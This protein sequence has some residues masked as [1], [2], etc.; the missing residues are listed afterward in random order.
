MKNPYNIG[1]VF[2]PDFYGRQALV[3]QL[4]DE[5][6]QCI[7]LVGNRR[8]GKTSMLR[9]LEE[10]AS[11]V[12]LFLDLMSTGASLLGME[13]GAGLVRQVRRKS[14]RHPFLKEL[15]FPE[16]CSICDAVAILSQA[17]E[18]GSYSVLLLI[19]EAEKLLEIKADELARLRSALQ[20]KGPL[21]TILAATQWLAELNEQ[22]GSPL[23]RPFLYGFATHYLPP[24][25]D[26]DAT[27]LILQVQNLE[28]QVQAGDSLVKRIRSLTGN[29]PFLIQKLCYQLFQPDGR[30]RPI[31]DPDLIIDN[32]LDDV[33]RNH[34]E[35]LSSNEQNVLDE[36]SKQ[37]TASKKKLLQLLK[38]SRD[39]LRSSLYNLEHLGDIRLSSTGYRIANHF[40]DTWLRMRREDDPAGSVTVVGTALAATSATSSPPSVS[41]EV[42]LPDV[43]SPYEVGVQAL[44]GRLGTGHPRYSEALVYQQRLAESI[45]QARRYGDTESLRAER[46]QIID[47][48]NA[49]SLDALGQSFNELCASSGAC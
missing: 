1:A 2:G 20:A 31:E 5:G 6:T 37:G 15:S 22:G 44:L 16:P 14:K 24:L 38:V 46:A 41:P 19:D 25:E 40:L 34:Y 48:L 35:S 11:G 23:G 4:L 9:Y 13:M 49:L 36:I 27:G 39:R 12:T 26:H 8:S 42:R 30:L 7:Y 43:Y 17:A 3:E 45:A 32:L 33:F 28:G 21:R 18:A 47:R 10:H 29:Q